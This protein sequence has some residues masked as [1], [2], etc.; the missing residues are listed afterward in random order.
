[1]GALESHIAELEGQIEPSHAEK[2]EIRATRAHARHS[3][4]RAASG[5]QRLRGVKVTDDRPRPTHGG[6]HKEALDIA[7][8]AELRRRGLMPAD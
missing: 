4:H 2:S 1:V 7:W 5:I 8:D 6:A 3:D